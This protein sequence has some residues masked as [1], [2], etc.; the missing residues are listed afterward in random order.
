MK[1]FEVTIEGIAPLLHARH[2]SPIEEEEITK[3]SKKDGKK[4]KALTDKEQFTIHSY[5]NAAGKFVQPAEMVEAAMTKA[6]ANFRMEGKK[7]Y[8]DAIKG[9]MF[10]TPIE[11]V[12]SIQKAEM[13]SRWGKNPTTR[14]AVWVVRPRFDKWKLS[15]T[16][17]LLLDER[18]ADSTIKEIL[19]YAGLYI[20]LGAWRPKFGR[21][22]VISFKSDSE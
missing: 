18:V 21:F 4:T 15:F 7:T 12:H 9:G 17:N 16:I 5:K 6:A 10:V 13:D 19:D 11:I 2:P 22:E 20:G 3:R 14:G 1:K 8:K